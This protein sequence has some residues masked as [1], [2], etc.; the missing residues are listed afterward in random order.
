MDIDIQNTLWEINCDGYYPYCPKCRYEPDDGKLT[1]F[2]PNCGADL[3][4][5]NKVLSKSS[6]ELTKELRDITY[7]ITF[8]KGK[9][10]VNSAADKIEQLQKHIDDMTCDHFVDTLDFYLERCQKLE[11]DLIELGM[12]SENI[13][14]YCKNNIE[15]KDKECKKYCE[16]K[17]AYGQDGQYFPDWRWN[18][19]D[20]D[21]GTCPLL[22]NTPCNGCFENNAKGF[23]W[24]GNK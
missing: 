21:F 6:R 19:K 18:C 24:R 13:C 14:S 3:R 8:T 1:Y 5:E 9:E 12:C 23:E 17:G 11:E 22:E 2:C 7:H 15:C 4:K 20:F 16:G 10:I